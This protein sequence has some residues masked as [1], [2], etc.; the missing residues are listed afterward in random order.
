MK[1]FF[2]LLFIY[3]LVIG[4]KL[5]KEEE[6]EIFKKALVRI[7]SRTELPFIGDTEEVKYYNC[8]L[9]KQPDS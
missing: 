3:H 9:C 1:G 7:K 6:S 8:S 2:K 4:L 5:K